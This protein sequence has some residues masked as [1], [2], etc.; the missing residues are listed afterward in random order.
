MKIKDL[1]SSNQVAGEG[2]QRWSLQDSNGKSIHIELLGIHIS[3]AEDSLFSLQ[4]LIKQL[5]VILRKLRTN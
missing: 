4:V 1:S 5:A 3:N 2:I